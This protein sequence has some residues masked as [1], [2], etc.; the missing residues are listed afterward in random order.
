MPSLFVPVVGSLSDVL[1]NRPAPGRA[2][3]L[4]VPT[5]DAFLFRD[6]GSA[7]QRIY[8]GLVCS[9]PPA[10]AALTWANQGGSVASTDA[11]G[12][13]NLTVPASAT[14]AVRGLLTSTPATPYTFTLGLSILMD[15]N[16]YYIAGLAQRQSGLDYWLIW[17][18][19]QTGNYNASS[20]TSANGNGSS[21]STASPRQFGAS[22]FLR[23]R[24]DGVNRTYSVSENGVDFY[25]CFT[26]G[27][28]TFMTTDQVG[29]FGNSIN[30]R[31]INIRVFHWSLTQG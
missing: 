2:G 4:F 23:V 27:A 14:T 13:L 28:T 21:V 19:G 15:M 10:V 12:C 26:Q 1:A 24:N 20:H 17:G 9:D 30:S 11:A 31:P 16:G 29:V 25:D 22:C 7:W 6:T 5:D 3:R 18:P 8:R